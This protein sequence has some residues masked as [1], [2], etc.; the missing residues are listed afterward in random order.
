MMSTWVWL[1][2]SYPSSLSEDTYREVSRMMNLWIILWTQAPHR[3]NTKIYLASLTFLL[4]LMFKV[5]RAQATS[6]TDQMDSINSNMENL[7]MPTALNPT[8]RSVQ[9][10]V[11]RDVDLSLETSP[12]E[13]IT[14]HHISTSS[15]VKVIIT[16]P[17]ITIS[18]APKEK[19]TIPQTRFTPTPVTSFK[20]ITENITKKETHQVVAW[21]T[22]CNTFL[23][24]SCRYKVGPRF[25]L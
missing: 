13:Q 20:S 10:S 4:F 1:L 15:P 18:S 8:G 7:T 25:H 9:S 16:R 23:S 19:T 3:M 17:V 14:D 21:E 6:S 5:S 22:Q 12:A 11:T 2:S 24:A